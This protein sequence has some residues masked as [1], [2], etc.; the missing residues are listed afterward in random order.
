MK[1]KLSRRNAAVW[2]FALIFTILPALLLS[3]C[4]NYTIPDTV[5][6]PSDSIKPDVVFETADTLTYAH[7]QHGLHNPKIEANNR[8]A[9]EYS[10]GECVIEY[11]V[12]AEGKAKNVGFL[13]FLNGKPQ[14]YHLDIG[15]TDSYLN[16]LTLEKDGELTP[17][18]FYFTP[19]QG[20]QGETLTLTILSLYYPDFQPDMIET[21]SY[22]AY[23]QIL[24]YTCQLSFKKDAPPAPEIT[25]ID[26]D[27]LSVHSEIQ[28]I[29]HE[30][31]SKELPANGYNQ[32]ITME[33]VEEQF[34]H[35]ML[36]NG[37][38]VYDHLS[39]EPKETI[40][41]SYKLCGPTGSEYE[42][43]FFLNHQPVLINGTPSFH[44]SLTKGNMQVI[45]ADLDM[46]FLGDKTTF[47]AITI[48]VSELI[49]SFPVKT[50]SI[51]FYKEK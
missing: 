47:Y 34:Y 9:L 14:P 6:E 44:T 11:E 19:V 17:F 1:L 31:L 35:S 29:T 50:D 42:T 16:S 39:A 12:L 36:Y 26:K 10:G 25:F 41:L 15:G 28:K 18:Q 13:L 33:Q 21:S 49:D 40:H 5:P 27:V 7:I 37:K 23:H 3:G 48:P 46:S 43:I 51:L 20:K 24:P 4:S 2:F 38:I 30:F 45:E 8:L 22:G 32:E